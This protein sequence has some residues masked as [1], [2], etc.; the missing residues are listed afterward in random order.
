MQVLARKLLFSS[1]MTATVILATGAVSPERVQLRKTLFFDPRLS[2][3][4]VVE[5][6]D[7]GGDAQDN[8]SH[9]SSRFISPPRKRPTWS[10][11]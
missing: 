11:S 8:L 10:N 3:E 4:E 2:L 7:R 9:T 5:H 6:C 1:A